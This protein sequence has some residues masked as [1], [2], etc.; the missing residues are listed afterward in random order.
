MKEHESKIHSCNFWTDSTTVLQWIHSSHRKQQVFVANRVAEILDTTNVSQWNHV[1]GI[2]NPADI[3]TRAIN[4]DELKRSEGL[5]GPAWLKQRENEWPE[6]LNLTFASDEENDEM[7]FSAKVEEKKPMF[8]WERISS[9][10][11]LEN[12]MA[13]VQRVFIKHKPA[14]KTL[15]VEEREGAQENKCIR[16]RKGRAQTK[17]PVMA[18]LPEER[19]VASTVFSN[20]GVDYFGPFT[21]KIGRRNEKRWCCLFTCLT[22]R[23]VHIKIVPKLNTDSCLNAIMRFIARRGKPVKMISDNG[24]NFVGAEKELAEYIAAWNKV[25]IEEHLIQQ[26]IRWKF[27]PPAA[28]HF[29]VW[30][31]LV[32]SCKKAMYAVLG[33]RSVTEDV[34]STTMCLIE[35]MLNARPLTQVR[36][37]AT[38]LEAITPNHFLLGNKNLCLPYLSGA[39]Q[40][41]D[42]RKL[43]RQTHAYA[44]LIWDRFRKE[45]LPTLNSRK[46]WQTTTDRSLQQGDLVWLVEDSD[47]SGYYDLGGKTETKHFLLS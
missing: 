10:N 42:H 32:R 25:R 24:T 45:Y 18:D 39:E 40:F 43:F 34:L 41:V 36:S 20:V 23:A 30:E 9:F 12:T 33:N 6:Q 5:S 17:A 35:Q 29:G 38:D 21:V 7:V 4:V 27:N 13:Y 46:K 37:D 14:T 31:R 16:C 28:P 2:N 47:K 8:Q 26:G 3:G 44:D 22:V 19:L 1:S 11:R 15:S